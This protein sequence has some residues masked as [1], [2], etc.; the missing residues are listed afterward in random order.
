[1]WHFLKGCSSGYV[2]FSVLL[3]SLRFFGRSFWGSFGFSVRSRNISSLLEP[4][5]LSFCR[6]L[7]W[8]DWVTLFSTSWDSLEVLG[9]SWRFLEV[10]GGYWK[11]LGVLEA[12]K[13]VKDC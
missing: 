2:W 13:S 1:M 7:L 6:C 3:D 4:C 12:R 8:F 10:L 9:G 5:F 11:F